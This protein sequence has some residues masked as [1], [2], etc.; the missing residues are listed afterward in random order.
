MPEQIPHSLF[1]ESGYEHRE[2]LF[3]MPPYGGSI[4]QT[5]YYAESDLC[6]ADVDTSKGWPKREND[7]NGKMKPWDPPFIL[8][9]DRGGC[10]F[11]KKVRLWERGSVRNKRTESILPVWNPHN[12]NLIFL[13]L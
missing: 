12:V 3:G 6:E 2:A 9:V 4:A 7:K 11:V 1:K 13:N 10:T 5:V 8:M